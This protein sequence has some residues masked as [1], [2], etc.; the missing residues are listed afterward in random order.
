MHWTALWYNV[1]SNFLRNGAVIVI[2]YQDLDGIEI[3]ADVDVSIHR[4]KLWRILFLMEKLQSN[5]DSLTFI[6]LI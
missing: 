5:T 3:G 6:A 4:L 2:S 1:A